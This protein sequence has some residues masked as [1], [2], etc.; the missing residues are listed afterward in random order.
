MFKRDNNK[1]ENIK[2]SLLSTGIIIETKL[3]TLS[4]F[5]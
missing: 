2:T 5:K 4:K 1:N 3:L